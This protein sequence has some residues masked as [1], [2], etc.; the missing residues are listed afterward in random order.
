MRERRASWLT[1]SGEPGIG[2]TRLLRALGERADEQGHLVLSGRAAEFERELPFAVWVDA[3]DAYVAALGESRLE[4]LVGDRLG[5]LS[6]VLPSAAAGGAA[7]AA[8]AGGLQDERFRAYRAVHALLEGLA[9]AQGGVVLVLDDL[10]WA[11][12]ASLELLAHMLRRPPRGHALIA[13]AFRAGRLPG[14]V[15]AAIEAAGRDRGLAEVEL[16]PLSEEESGALLGTGVGAGA[17]AQLFR[18]SGGNPFYLEQLARAQARAPAVADPAG[19]GAMAGVPTAVASALGQEIAALEETSRRLAWGAAVAGETA[20]LELAAATAGLQPSEAL[21]ALDGLLDAG[22]F[23]RT[24]VPRQYRMRHPI[25]RQAVFETAGEG[26]RIEAHARAAAALEASHAPA[27][28]RALHLERCAAPGDEA[29]IAVLVQA[30]RDAAARAPAG[31][32]RWFG[33]ALRLLGPEADAGRRLELLIPLATSLAATGRLQAALA[34]LQDALELVPPAFAE[35]R[36]R[37][38]AACAACEN[39]LGRHEAAHRRLL[40]T[41]A[42]IEEP[43]GPAAGTLYAELAADALYDSDFA[44][45]EGWAA[46]ARGIAAAGGDAGLGA[47][48]AGLECFAHYGLGATAAAR[49]AQADGAALLDALDDGALAGRLEAPYY[50]GF[51]EYFCER[52]DDAIRHLRRGIAVSR[53]VG[54]GQFVVPMMV[55]LSSALW[56]RG[57]M[58]EAVELAEDAGEAARLAGN[59]QLAGWALVAEAIAA[60]SLGDLE[61]ALAAA[62]EAVALVRGLDDSVLTRA[63]QAHVSWVW[64]VA[65]RPERCLE[66]VPALG[67][68]ELPWIEP[69]RRAW[70][71]SVLA[72]AELA[73]GNRRGAEEWA[74][75]GEATAAGLDLP[76]ADANVGH[77]RA[78][79]TLETGDARDAARGAAAAAVAAEAVGAVVDAARARALEGRAL[80][81]AGDSEAAAERLM[82]AEA[83]LA[84]CGAAQFRDEAARE[85]RRLGR[86]VG[87]RQRRGAGA[88]GL[89]GLSGREREVADLVAE[90]R[91]NREI[92]GQLFLSEKTVESHLAKVF[93]KLGVGSRA[94]VAETVGRSRVQT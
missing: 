44:A 15:A 61:R 75:R 13:L 85:L 83:E 54:Q 87:A 17:R 69:G 46:R 77:A 59:D 45:M 23:Q 19:D 47:A 30:G 66:A 88:D 67:G 11:D 36:V 20:D 6:R 38:I 65:G 93:K 74:Q 37:L 4:R 49:A 86:R 50:L 81:A 10:H 57:R 31:A 92:A 43:E 90:G 63:T 70:L 51:A 78:Q 39:L 28:A 9:G 21:G 7:E 72:R 22:L 18:E 27:A 14:W 33:A 1:V 26:W 68:P 29:A 16:S 82:R 32:A 24:R 53:A 34:T 42:D 94:A 58:A 79:L 41:R 25:V 56:I 52:Y 35:V 84:A 2:K 71:Y 89:E 91:T 73:R 64:L 55:G 5:E 76:V 3:L 8:A 62:E 60:A 80:A 48:A 40:A 12:D